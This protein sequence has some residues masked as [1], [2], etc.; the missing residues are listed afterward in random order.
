[1]AARSSPAEAGIVEQRLLDDVEHRLARIERRE[2]VLVDELDLP[3]ELAQRVALERRDVH[4]IHQNSARR[5]RAEAD[6]VADGGG[7]ART[8]LADQCVRRAPPHS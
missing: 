7:L 1:L 6:D 5:R 3:A 2:R 8:G 4:A